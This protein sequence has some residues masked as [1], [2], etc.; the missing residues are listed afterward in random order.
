MNRNPNLEKLNGSYLFPKIA[1][2]KAQFLAEH[3][4]AQ[5]ISLGV[6]D[7]TEPIP[8]SITQSLVEI[9]QR[10]GTPD[11]YLGYGPEQGIKPLRRK[12]ASVVYQNRVAPEEV[13]I[14]DGAN[15]DIARL[16]TL[17]GSQ[18][19]VAIQD[20]TYP[21]YLDGS[22]IQGVN[23]IRFMPCSMENGF[24]PDLD[25]LPNVDLIYF[26]SPNNPTGS[27]ASYSELERLVAFAKSHRSIIIFDAAY[28]SYIRN[29]PKTIFDIPGAN[30]VAIEV[31]SFSKWAGF[32]GIRLGWSVVP[33]A[34][35]YKNGASVRS[36]WDR[37]VSTLFNGASIIAQYGG[38]AVL[39]EQGLKEVQSLTDF[40][41]ENA[42]LLKSVW[43]E[44]GFAAFGGVHS[45][46]VWVHFPGK[47]SWEVFQELLEKA[48]IV[49]IPGSGFGRAGEGFIR[50]SAYGKR[51]TI[52]HAME[53]IYSVYQV[54]VAR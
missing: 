14:S 4:D 42:R 23:E 36:D 7:T 25:L 32:T 51:E 31:G 21:V 41:L 48:H 30:E 45:P 22:I 9:S 47:K 40:Y 11:G 50:L 49:T 27:A 28:A 35:K 18:V 20:P 37:V 43:S 5:L 24:F 8:P 33:E 29:Q 39:E 26:C 19:R 13:F 54:P 10:L 17:F 38:L 3:P 46:Y 52:L 16:Q 53:R 1:L 2:R 15:C 12:I 34:L 44:L 6:G